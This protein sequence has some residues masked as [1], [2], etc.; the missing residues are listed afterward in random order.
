MVMDWAMTAFTVEDRERRDVRNVHAA[1]HTHD[2]RMDAVG[3][4]FLRRTQPWCHGISVLGEGRL[5]G[6]SAQMV[7]S[8][9]CRT[10]L[11]PSPV[12]GIGAR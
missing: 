4:A 5:Q 8:S 10:P 11:H 1:R 3:A 7:P 2:V 9:L 6:R 12:E